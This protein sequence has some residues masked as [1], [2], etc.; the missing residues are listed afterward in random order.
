MEKHE[1]FGRSGSLRPSHRWTFLLAA[2]GLLAACSATEPVETTEGTIEVP[3][4]SGT[5]AVDL[6]NLRA[7]FAAAIPGS[8]IAFGPGTYRIGNSGL[9]LTTD[10][11]T[12]RG[13]TEGT[14][15]Q[16]CDPTQVAS[17]TEDL[18]FAQCQGIRLLGAR[19]RVRNLTFENF[20]AALALGGPTPADAEAPT[21]NRHGGHII[22]GNTLRNCITVEIWSDADAPVV[23]RGNRFQNTYHAAAMLGR[24]VHFIDNDVS[25]PEPEHVPFGWPSLAVGLRPIPG[26]P[27]TGNR[28]ERNRIEG[29]TDGVAIGV[30]PPD[31]PGAVLADNRVCDNEIVM[32]DVVHSR[33]GG[34]AL[35]GKPAIG[36]AIRLMN[37]QEAMAIGALDLGMPTPEGGWPE[38]CRSAAVRGNV[39]AGNR[40]TG[41]KGV[42]IEVFY[43]DANEVVRNIIGPVAALTE[44]ER[45][46]LGAGRTFGIGPGAWF[47]TRA[48]QANGTAIWIS[49]GS[50]GNIVA[51]NKTAGNP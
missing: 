50:D 10:H 29:H 18:F 45:L 46:D 42:A 22:E 8:T 1:F 35:A 31:G 15:L 51:E 27:C 6:A 24:N 12:L 19:Q 5:A 28:I 47:L 33:D 39:V 17:M 36:V 23:V 13:H 3:P 49:P 21:P 7:A 14:V 20:S 48:W 43:A 32:R 41:S 44:Q 34:E 11:V 16:G 30:L 40:I 9:E 38:A 2:W 25:A 37:Y 4:P 26:V